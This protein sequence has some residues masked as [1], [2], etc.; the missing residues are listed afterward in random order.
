MP[1]A[2]LQDMKALHVDMQPLL[3]PQCACGA[4]AMPTM[5]SKGHA[6]GQR[7]SNAWRCTVPIPPDSRV[8][9]QPSAAYPRAGM[10]D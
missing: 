5:T 7:R 8:T 6:L 4:L 2:M 10:A 9:C 3:T 1:P